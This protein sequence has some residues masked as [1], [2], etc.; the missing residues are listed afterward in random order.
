MLSLFVPG[1]GQIY[2]GN[3]ISGLLWLLFVIIGY[4]NV[5]FPLASFFT[6]SVSSAHILGTQ[7]N[8]RK[9]QIMSGAR[10]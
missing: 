2:K 4:F 9:S 6:S 1:A 7:R 8:S 3:I 5:I 10:A